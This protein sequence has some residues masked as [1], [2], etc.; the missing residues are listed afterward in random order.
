LQSVRGRR[1]LFVE[2]EYEWA[3]SMKETNQYEC[4]PG[5]GIGR[6]DL[7]DT[8]ISKSEELEQIQNF[9]LRLAKAHSNQKFVQLLEVGCGTGRVLPAL[10]CASTRVVGIDLDSEYL[11]RARWRIDELELAG[12]S[13]E[14]V[15]LSNY[16]A[17][18]EFDCVS[19]INGCFYYFRSGGELLEAFSKIYTTLKPGGVLVA[20]GGNLLHHLRY[21]GEGL[22]VETTRELRGKQVTRFVRHELDLLNARWI[23]HDTY[24][25]EGEP[26]K[27][28]SE[29]YCFTIF[30]PRN[31]VDALEQV[32]FTEIDTK[33]G[34]DYVQGHQASAR[35]VVFTAR[36]PARKRCEAQKA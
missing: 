3:A 23:H 35:R 6:A 36:K 9:H 22:P 19:I 29:R 18:S 11:M 2:A 26:E 7:Y 13:V 15:P 10:A 14:Q 21:Y 30:T 28:F 17:Q 32:G 34:W 1:T 12:V 25:I 16:Q 8:F 5:T 33:A 27:I 4:L 24:K 20:E 31:L